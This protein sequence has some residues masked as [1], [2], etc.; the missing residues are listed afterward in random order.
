MALEIKK[1]TDLTT[2]RPGMYLIYSAP[3]IGKTSTIKYLQGRTLVLDV[4]RTTGVLTGTDNIDI[5]EVDTYTPYTTFP[6]LLADIQKNYLDQYDN[7][8]LDN[9]SELERSIMSQLGREGKNNRV[10]SMANYQQMQFT[11][12]D[13]IRFMKSW[14]KN[15]VITAWEETDQWQTMSGQI[16]NRA[17]P[18]IPAKIR[19]NVMGLADVVGR[20]IY[21]QE[22]DKRGFILQPTN[23]VFA[24]NQIDARHGALQSE[25]F[26]RG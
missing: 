15:I 4:D 12:V 6:K 18:K 21:D 20:L 17:Y 23:A 8:V 9:V 22:E 1:A 25:L 24:K 5:V 10:P 13:A 3:G 14:N 16:Y 26:N 2:E 19:D 11:I 7:I